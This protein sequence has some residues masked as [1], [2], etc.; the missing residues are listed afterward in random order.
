L[1]ECFLE[2]VTNNTVDNEVGGSIADKSEITEAGETEE[3]CGRDKLVTTSGKGQIW[4][5]KLSINKP[6]DLIHHEELKA[7]EK[8][9]GD[10]TDNKYGDNVDEDGSHVHLIPDL[11][12]SDMGVPTV[13]VLFSDHN[14][15]D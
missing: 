12:L 13:S 9:P 14:T 2:L 11:P 10:T 6:D 8:N 1:F 5:T 7:V 3:P 15:C 4:S